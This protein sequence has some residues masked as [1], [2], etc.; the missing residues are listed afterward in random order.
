VEV[1][2]EIHKVTAEGPDGSFTLLPRHADFVSA[3]APGLLLY[4]GRGGERLLA[5]NGG[6]LVKCGDEV[7]VSTPEA[8][9]GRDL[10]ELEKAVEESFENLD[11]RESRA[12]TAL[13]KLE[14]DLVRRF[15]ELQ[16]HG[17]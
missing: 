8:I 10:N 2:E 4:E 12:R 5:V 17:R 7:L 11:E 14:A 9:R 15:V 1:D 3:L 13:Q 6:T 16:E